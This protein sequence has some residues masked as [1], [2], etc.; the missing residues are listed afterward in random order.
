MKK[1]LLI[2]TLLLVTGLS[3]LLAQN[4]QINPIPSYNFP[5]SSLFTAFQE[6]PTHSAPQREKRDMDIVISSSSSNPGQVSAKVWVVKENALLALGPFTVYPDQVLSV[7]IDNGQWGV[8]IKTDDNVTA[9][10]WID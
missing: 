9:S 2:V 4:N 5:I 3:D 1:V 7:P 6:K 10:V 8:I